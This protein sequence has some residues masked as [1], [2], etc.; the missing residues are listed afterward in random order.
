VVSGGPFAPNETVDFSLQA[1]PIKKATANASGTIV[2]FPITVPALASFGLTTLTAVGETSQKA[3]SASIDIANIWAQAGY[4]AV[5]TGFEPHDT[6]LGTTLQS[7][8]EGYLSEAWAFDSGAAVDTSP[9][10]VGGTAYVA[11]AAGTLDAVDTFAGAPLWTASIPTKAPIEGAPAIGIGDIVLGAEDGS[12]YRF[13]AAN[14]APIGTI[15]LDGV[16][17][18]PTL[19]GGTI[20][21]GTDNGTVFALSE[22]TGS[23]IW[24]TAIGS[25]VAQAPT[26][27]SANELVIVG[28][29]GGHITELNATTG[30]VVAVLTTGG[31]AVTVPPEI[32]GGL[33]LVGAA[34]GY[35]RAF[36]ETTGKLAWKF[37]AG[38]PI[39]SLAST[40][41]A[42][43]VGSDS[44]AITKLIEAKGTLVYQTLDD[45]SAVIGIGHTDGVSITAT[46]AGH[47]NA[48]K[49]SQNG[50]IQFN[51][52]TGK[53]LDTQPVI[54]DGTVYIGAED[55]RLY[56]FTNH[57][58]A[59]DAI[60][61]RALAQL[62]AIAPIPIAWTNPRIS[63]HAFDATQGFAP[64]GPRV[65][66]IHVDRTPPSPAQRF[67]V[68]PAGQT[69]TR[70]YLIGWAP[71]AVRAEA[72]VTRARAV[73]G[74]V[75]G[76]TVDTAP[77]P[78]MLDDGAIQRE[79]AN[80]IARNG[81]RPGPS[82]RF[83]VL[84][85]ESPVSARE[86][87]SYHSAFDLNGSP[88]DPVVYGVIPAG[89]SEE[90]GP[91]GPQIQRETDE[92]TA[93]P[94]VRIRP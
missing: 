15:A 7:T 50:R 71:V 12:L 37:N 29:V 83:V 44:G 35:L 69:R 91:F 70:T 30:A 94:Y 68:A 53:G 17:T 3:S 86:Y 11:N 59:P 87:C 46:K 47:I 81:W 66:P 14:G 48:L 28:D 34:D 36:R 38:S 49:D 65:F 54:V 40:G 18:S 10:V 90:C 84:T 77:Y 23:E 16:P 76:T 73:S 26:V 21:T 51:F 2:H 79:I 72:F 32:S 75:A 27:D 56:A 24:S 85:A 1:G 67:A 42:V 61:H 88:L 63:Q 41:D 13:S 58:Q 6:V 43:Y 62:R 60:E 55:G 82:A 52:A 92:L 78:R 57:G 22:S 9:L 80:A 20:Y 19:A 93:D 25:P 45:G 64:H 8:S 39:D 5:H 4:D 31:A 74:A 89:T 33:L